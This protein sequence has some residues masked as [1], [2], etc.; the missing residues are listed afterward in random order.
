ML[1]HLATR[2]DD[3]DAE[4]LLALVSESQHNGVRREHPTLLAHLANHVDGICRAVDGDQGPA[5]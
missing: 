5:T 3:P 1:L 2:L 4:A